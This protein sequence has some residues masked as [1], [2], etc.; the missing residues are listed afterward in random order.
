MAAGSIRR[1]L[2]VALVAVVGGVLIALGAALYAGVRDAAWQQHDAGLIA[3]AEALA[4]IGEREHG[5]YELDLPALPGAFA[6]AWTPDGSVLARSPGLTGDLPVHTGTFALTLP[7]GRDGRA[8]GV[9]FAPRDELH[10]APTELTLVL[11]EGIDDIAAAERSVRNRFLG[12]GALALA[13][14]GGLTAWSLARGLRPLGALTAQLARIDDRNLDVRIPDE[15]QP[16]ELVVPVRTLNELFAR[17]AAAFARERQFTANVSHELRTPLA[18][19]RTLLEVTARAPAPGDHA[20]ALAIVVEMCSVVESLLL[21]ARLDAGQL[22]V[23]RERVAL[24]ALVAECW[25]P[26]AAQA[27][28]RGLEVRNTIALDAMVTTD[29]DRLRVVIG[30]LLANAAEYTSAGGWIEVRSEAGGAG[31]DG[32]ASSGGGGASGGGASDGGASSGGGASGGGGG[33]WLEVIDSGPAIPAEQLARIFDRMWRGDAARSDTGVHCGIGL[34]LARSLAEHLG[35]TL[36]AASRADGSVCFRIAPDAVAGRAGW[37]D[38]RVGG[39][40]RG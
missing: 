6:E 15:G 27:A 17:L 40:M 12:F 7:D 35:L 10:R 31:G 5:G 11:A 21:L 4:A 29:R 23:V 39:L 22:E 38:G 32:G 36:T 1:R 37:R 30:N 14:V 24:G 25:R 8:F 26:Y 13:V 16:A 33:A 3:R 9:R 19:L 18:G 2:T 20:E 34:A 28:A